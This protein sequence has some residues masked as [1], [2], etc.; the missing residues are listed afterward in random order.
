MTDEEHMFFE[1]QRAA[2]KQHRFDRSRAA[3][4]GH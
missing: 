4:K 3:A 2:L 1:M